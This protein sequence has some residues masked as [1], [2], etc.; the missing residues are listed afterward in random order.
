MRH[1]CP[2]RLFADGSFVKE[3]EYEDRSHSSDENGRR[4][5][6][7]ITRV[8]LR[9]LASPL[10]LA[11][12]AFGVGS[13]LLSGQQ[14]GL[15]P[16]D[17]TRVV[18][19]VIGLFVFPL[20]ALA[21]VFAFL[22]RETLGATAIGLISASWL[23]TAVTSYTL[24]PG[25]TTTTL[26]L[27]QLALTAILLMLG[28]VGLSGKPLLAAVILLAAARYG[29]DGLHDLTVFAPAEVVSGVLGVV[30]FL[31]A[32]YGG[33]A[34]GLEDVKHRTVLPFGRRGEALDAIEGDI[35]DQIGPVEQE[36]GVRKQL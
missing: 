29:L 22:A 24:P 6:E 26:G 27:F 33:L 35:G 17:E 1:S 12:F 11:F 15:V 5:A 21:A 14:L 36:A 20:Q 7:E 34:L 9:P 3:N 25:T 4:S 10:P 32:L 8:V 23:T 31:F 28:F 13:L 19:L 18:A 2:R 30:I 16:L